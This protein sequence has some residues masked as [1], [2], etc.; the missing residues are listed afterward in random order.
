MK[1]EELGDKKRDILCPFACIL[2]VPF[3]PVAIPDATQLIK[4]KANVSFFRDKTKL[5]LGTA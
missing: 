3:H 1:C 2:F 4:I 5:Q